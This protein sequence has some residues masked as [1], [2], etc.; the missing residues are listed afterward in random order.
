MDISIIVP[1]FNCEKYLRRCLDSLLNQQI[2]EYEIL[3]INDCSNDNSMKI[4]EE[5]SKYYDKIKIIN[6]KVNEGVSKSRNIGILESKGEYIVFCDGDDSYEKNSISMMLEYARKNGSDFVVTNHC[7]VKKGKKILRDYV[8]KYKEE[9]PNKKNCIRNIDLSSC[10]KLVKRSIFIENEI[11]YPENLKRFEEYPV[12]PVCCFYAKKVSCLNIH[13]YNYYQNI[14]SASNSSLNDFS[15]FEIAFDLFKKRILVDDFKE[16]LEFREIE[17]ILYGKI[18][19]MLKNNRTR[20]EIRDEILKFKNKHNNYTNN[21]YYSDL[22]LSRKIFLYF[23]QR[24]S[25][26]A[27]KILSLIHSLITA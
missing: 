24:E 3:C 16:E 2:K 5:Y 14:N 17:H 15:V 20:N 22:S 8:S 10:G 26:T 21:K 11:F 23:V 4:L 1:I 25:Y 6:N 12:I 18:I 9:F 19:V 7:I 13:T 27:L